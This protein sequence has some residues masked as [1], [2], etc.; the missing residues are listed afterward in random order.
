M[1]SVKVHASEEVTVALK[2]HAFLKIL[3]QRKSWLGKLKHKQTFAI[4]RSF[5]V[6]KLRATDS[7]ISTDEYSRQYV[8][9]H[10]L[11]QAHSNGSCLQTT[12]SPIPNS[13]RPDKG[14]YLS[15]LRALGKR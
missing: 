7:N 2:F 11:V 8:I 14:S 3:S 6:N 9:C 4:A 12:F 10:S 5:I 13:I 15:E 1:L